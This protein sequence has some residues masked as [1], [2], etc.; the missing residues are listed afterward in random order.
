LG[1]TWQATSAP[2]NTLAH[3]GLRSDFASASR[4]IGFD[5]SEARRDAY[6]AGQLKY[7]AS[8]KLTL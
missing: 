7:L 3:K 1:K 4:G 8:N 5:L 6:A 2:H